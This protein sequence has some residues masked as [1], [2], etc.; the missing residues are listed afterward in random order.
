MKKILLS[1]FLVSSSLLYGETFELGKINVLSD[2]NSDKKFTDNVIYFEDIQLQ[3]KKS[4]SEALNTISGINV[5]NLGGRNEQMITLRGF[6]V[7]HAPLYIDGI[8]IA[9]AY[10]GY[11]DFSRFTTFDLSQIQVSKGL[12][13]V[14]LGSNNFAGAINLVTKKPT[15]ELEGVASIGVF[16]GNG[17][18]SYLNLGT[19]QGTYYVQGSVSYLDRD[20]FPMS[21]DF[22]E[23]SRQNNDKREQSYSEDKKLNLK[24]GYTP[25]ETDEYAVNYINQKADKGVPYNVLPS[26]RARY[27]KWDYWDKESIY[28]LSKTNFKYFYLKSRVF[29]DK[30]K[31][32]LSTYTDN[33]YSQ[34]DSNYAGWYDDDTKGISLE[35]GQY[36]TGK[37]SLKFAFH[38]KQD[39]HKENDGDTNKVYEMKV[40]TYSLGLENIYRFTNDLRLILGVSWDKD[41]IKKAD[42]TRYDS[43]STSGM[44]SIK[45]F[46]NTSATAFNPMAKI[47]YNINS[48]SKIYAGIAKKTRFASIKDRYSYRM[49]R[50]IPNPELKEEQA[51][52]YEIGFNKFFENQGVKGSVFYGDITDFIMTN[53]VANP[54]GSGTVDQN[55][56]VGEVRQRG[57][58]IEYF[59][60]FESGLIFDANYTRLLLEDKEDKVDITNAPKDKIALSFSYEP[61]RKLVTNI[62]M[63]YSS[64][65]HTQDD[66]RSKDVSGATI[67]NLKVAY[68]FT[69]ALSMD[70]GANNIFDKNY[71]YDYGFPEAGRVF[72][73]NLTYKF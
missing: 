56:N 35:L 28:F 60:N 13:S 7:K 52:N 36:D 67:W 54:S 39:S 14:L 71:E 20:N 48:S 16:S 23:T 59:Y 64:S 12:S 8:P 40:N 43:S 2:S 6:D 68:N 31:N 3:E 49:N 30:F 72:F 44:A 10:D 69:Q 5:Y 18:K 61:I 38:A 37:N 9:V 46:E 50:A 17:K 29:Y 25:N 73:A 27:W 26:E 53:K 41:D 70:I 51:T 47:E 33:S 4:I 32:Q 55:Q 45:E 1:S 34:L 15:K 63:Q 66:D 22:K 62:N 19:N 11:V 42:N 57:Y 21:D 58:E 24:V 65:R